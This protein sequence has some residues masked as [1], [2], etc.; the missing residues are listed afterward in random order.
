MFGAFRWR[1]CLSKSPGH[2]E[3]LNPSWKIKTADLYRAKWEF[4]GGKSCFKPKEQH[5]QRSEWRESTANYRNLNGDA[6]FEHKD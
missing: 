2:G 5:V 4:V 3:P 6:Q 1:L